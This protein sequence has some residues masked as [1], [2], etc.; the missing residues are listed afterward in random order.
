MNAEPILKEYIASEITRGRQS[1]LNTTDDL[2]ASGILDSLGILQLVAFI[3]ER[4][5]VRVADE[6]V[7]YENF[8]SIGAMANYLSTLQPEAAG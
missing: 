5:K 4:F 2:L 7:V 6:D 3:E 1:Q 8:Y